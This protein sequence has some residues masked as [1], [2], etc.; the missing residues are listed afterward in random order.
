[1]AGCGACHTPTGNRHVAEAGKEF[2]GGYEFESPFGIVVSPNIT[3]HKTGLGGWTPE[4]F[5]ERFERFRKKDAQVDVNP[6]DNTP[7]PWLE[8]AGM[9]DEDLEAIYAYLKTV[10]PVDH[11]VTVRPKK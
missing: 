6:R 4:R 2:S 8:Y 3:F 9:T 1:M 11:E 5:V 7:M 10:P